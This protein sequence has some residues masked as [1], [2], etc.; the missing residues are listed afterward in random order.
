MCQVLLADVLTSLGFELSLKSLDLLLVSQNEFINFVS[1]LG[2]SHLAALLLLLE[3][4]KVEGQLLVVRLK[5][6]IFALGRRQS[7]LQIADFFLQ[8]IG[9]VGWKATLAELVDAGI[10]LVFEFLFLQLEKL[11]LGAFEF[12]RE[13]LVFNLEAL[14]PLAHRCVLGFCKYFSEVQRQI[15]KHLVLDFLE[16]VFDIERLHIDLVDELELLGD[17]QVRG[18]VQDVHRHLDQVLLDALRQ[19]GAVLFVELLA[20]TAFLFNHTL[21]LIVDFLDRDFECF[22]SL[23]LAQGLLVGLGHLAGY[24]KHE[25]VGVQLLHSLEVPLQSFLLLASLVKEVFPQRVQLVLI[26]LNRVEKFEDFLLNEFEQITD[27]LPTRWIVDPS[28]SKLALHLPD[29]SL[30]LIELGS[31]FLDDSGFLLDIHAADVLALLH[32]LVL[33]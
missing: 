9:V 2:L 33:S 10:E 26:P 15:P 29:A 8:L 1:Q 13:H 28:I 27:G 16:L 6:L 22:A 5:L 11:V 21:K 31:E 23:E 12:I 25:G 20:V 24:L 7:F 18:A 3:L 17:L 30:L 19:V 4:F 32:L 14:Q